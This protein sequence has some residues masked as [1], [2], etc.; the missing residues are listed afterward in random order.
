MKREREVKGIGAPDG[1]RLGKCLR[2][3]VCAPPPSYPLLSPT[4]FV[5]LDGYATQREQ[6]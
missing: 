3:R 4:P 5:G 6:G 1:R 2:G